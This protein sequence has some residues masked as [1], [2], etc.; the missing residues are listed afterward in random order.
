MDKISDWT[1]TLLV[2]L[3]FVWIVALLYSIPL[4]LLWNWLMPTL[5]NLPTITFL[6][7]IGLNILANVLFKSNNLPTSNKE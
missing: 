1:A 5:F 3:T 2:T 4:Y 6:Q 7:S